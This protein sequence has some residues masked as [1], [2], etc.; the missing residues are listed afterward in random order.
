D[1]SAYP[2]QTRQ[3]GD[4]VDDA[5]VIDAVPYSD[6]GT[7]AGYTNDYDEEC[8]YTGSSSPD[9]V[10]SFNPSSDMNI[11][12]SLCSDGNEYDTK[13]YVY[14]GEVGTLAAAFDV[15]SGTYGEACSDDD[16]TNSYTNFASYLPNVILTGGTT[17]YIVVDGYGGENGNYE[18]VISEAE[19]YGGPNPITAY[20]VYRDGIEIGQTLG[21]DNMPDPLF[22]DFIPV[23]GDHEY[24]VTAWYDY[25][26]E[27][28]PSST[29]TVTVEAPGVVLY[30]PTNLSAVV[31]DTIG[32]GT[33]DLTLGWDS[34]VGQPG[35]FSHAGAGFGT[36]IGT[37]GDF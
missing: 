17:Y 26:G 6:A 13:L 21:P 3:G 31:D 25:Y 29:V 36:G 12:V 9:V 10:Y 5:V 15:S 28:N 35:W 1:Q 37:G 20:S 16:C 32:S 18:L 7:T 23:E 30:P 24:Y 14:E 27:S 33:N 8:P 11:E 2:D 22:T 19:Y 34:P 4:T